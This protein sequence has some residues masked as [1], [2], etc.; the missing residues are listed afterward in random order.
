MSKKGYNKVVLGMLILLFVFLCGMLTPFRSNAAT[1]TVKIKY[2][3]KTYKNKSKKLK[4]K[5][6][7][8]TISKS[9]YKALIINKNYMVPYNDIFKAVKA[10][11]S[12]KKST[13]AIVI[14]KN[15]VTVKMKLNSKTAYVNGKKVKL[16]TAPLS[17]RYLK[18][19]KTKILIPISYVAKAIHMTY[20][21]T[22][23]LI[24]LGDSLHISYDNTD[25]Y[26]T[27]AQGSLYY[28]H[29]NYTLNDLP[30]IKIDGVMYC[31]AE[32]VISDILKLDY[33]YK[34]DTGI[35]T[36]TNLDTNLSLTAQLN[37]NTLTVNEEPASMSKPVRIIRNVATSKDIVCIPI[38][39]V[40]KKLDYTCSWDKPNL[41]YNVQSKAFLSWT[42]ELGKTELAA[43]DINYIYS[44]VSDYSESNGTGS[45][46][47]NITGSS[48]DIMQKLTIKRSGSVITVTFPTS[49]YYLDKNSFENF[50]EIIDKMEVINN[51]DGSV[52]ITYNCKETADF[53]YVIK[54]D[55]L[56]LNVLYTYSKKDGSVTNYSLSIPKPSG[57][58]FSD[59]SNKDL[60]ASKKFKIIIK[61]NY[62]DYFQKNPVVI[63]NNSVKKVTVTNVDDKTQIT[64]KTS[65][66][67][68]YKIYDKGN[69][70]V[71]SVGSPKKI[72][73]SILVLDA[74]HGG[75]DPG[76]Q[77]KGTNE[78]DLTFRI[79]Y[80]LMKKHFT[81]NAP[82]IK[83]Y[84]TRTS[85]TF[86]TLA[87]RAAFAK[88]MG[89]DAFISLHMNSASNSSA[90]GT[91]VY[92]STN[93]NSKSFSGITSKKMATMFRKKIVSE[94]GM[95]N[96][97]TKTAGY[98]VIKHNTVPAILIELGFISGSSDYNKLTNSTFQTNAANT[99]YNQIVSMF[100][101]YPTGR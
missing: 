55:T 33:E 83:V 28:N 5:Y 30:I 95:K 32:E 2:N 19:K 54:E 7:N 97:G 25:V 34:E 59:V 70:I 13:K 16:P 82:D 94:L 37:T 38:S 9:A 68:G 86:I 62:A 78:K 39:A 71:V 81:S 80:T 15:D 49:K 17:V 58:T 89:A 93:N 64:V 65:S 84:W 41:C 101:T 47:F 18:K 12:Y 35:L 44:M 87:N 90:N 6:N 46:N 60:Y 76:A 22:S 31:P 92:Y 4:V 23:S 69:N 36:V 91:E 100:K 96:R 21:K 56:Q 8:K 57:V 75:H 66:L 27:G 73:K 53:S 61:G 14:K 98:Y 45:I 63:N 74:G 85:D 72:Y 52:S 10:T 3:G 77:N 48:K 11:C 43:T 51:E 67:Q 24:T 99:I 1:A 50:G 40:L 42:K 26:Y 29:N 20:K 79:L 88:K